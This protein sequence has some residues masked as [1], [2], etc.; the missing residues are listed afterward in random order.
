[1]IMK[2]F[3]EKYHL[4]YENLIFDILFLCT[5][6]WIDKYRTDVGWLSPSGNNGRVNNLT[7]LLESKSKPFFHL[8]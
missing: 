2:N 7:C 8:A 3:S 4:Q 1:M 6:E 5:P